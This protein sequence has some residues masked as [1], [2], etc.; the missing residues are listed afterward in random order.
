MVTSEDQGCERDE[1]GRILPGNTANSK[2]RPKQD[3]SITDVIRT[4]MDSKPDVKKALGQTVIKMALGERDEDGKVTVKPDLFAI[5]LIW[6]YLDGKPTQA[7]GITTTN[8]GVEELAR[9]MMGLNAD[10]SDANEG[11]EE[12]ST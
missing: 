3:H 12:E 5:K 6:A 11:T 8:S 9:A 4:M 10:D 7:L 2:G 1:Q